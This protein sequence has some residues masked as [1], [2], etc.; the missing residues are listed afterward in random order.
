M[1]EAEA[2]AQGHKVKLGKFPFA[3]LGRA[4]SIRET[5]GFVKVVMDAETKRVLGV[6]VVGPSASDLI[7]EAMLAV[8][9]TASAED[10]ALTVHPHPTLGEAMMEA[11]AAALG[12]AIHIANR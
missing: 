5:D 2:S 12:Q 4:M 8:E 6:T 10:L 7:S 3:A 9:M 1:S 11:G